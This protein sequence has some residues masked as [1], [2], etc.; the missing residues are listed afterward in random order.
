MEIDE[1]GVDIT[2]KLSKDRRLAVI[3]ITA[4]ASLNSL[5]LAWALEWYIV[6]L[7]K[8]DAA[9]REKPKRLI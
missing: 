7:M 9:E 2:I 4:E 1:S 3:K 6:K 5:D 8:I